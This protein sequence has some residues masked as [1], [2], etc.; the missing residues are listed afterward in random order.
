MSKISRDKGKRFELQIAKFFDTNRNHFES[1]DIRHP[2]LSIECKHRNKLPKTIVKWYMQAQAACP[3]DRIP[4]VA[5]HE[6]Y[7]PVA[8]S[9]VLISLSDLKKLID[10]E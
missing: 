8:E 3:T 4:V 1:E 5:M 7:Q 6:S 2:V 10:K 9:L